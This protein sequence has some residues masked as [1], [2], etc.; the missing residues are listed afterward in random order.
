MRILTLVSGPVTTGEPWI[1]E[2]ADGE[3]VPQ[4]PHTGRWWTREEAQGYVEEQRAR[5]A[6]FWAYPR[7]AI[8]LMI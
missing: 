2:D 8:G 6:E 4:N 7:T 5:G 1:V 3:L